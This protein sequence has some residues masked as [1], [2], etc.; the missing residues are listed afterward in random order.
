MLFQH[1]HFE[2]GFELISTTD[3]LQSNYRQR[4]TIFLAKVKLKFTFS[5]Y[6]ENVIESLFSVNGHW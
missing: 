6:H 4:L 2:V 3:A 5:K 1:M